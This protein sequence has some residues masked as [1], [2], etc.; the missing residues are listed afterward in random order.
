M[1]TH[2][3]EL[4]TD[5]IPRVVRWQLG[6]R[7]EED[8]CVPTYHLTPGACTD[9]LALHVAVA[10]GL[11]IGVI[12]SARRPDDVQTLLLVVFRDAQLVFHRVDG[13]RAPPEWPSTLYVIDTVDGVYVGESDHLAQRLRVHAREKPRIRCAYAARCADKSAARALEATLIRELRFR[14]VALL[15]DADGAHRV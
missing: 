3:H 10:V 8:D 9:S 15:S 6:A 1:S 4:S 13:Q 5:T 7:I 14:D 12:L 11:P 2:Y